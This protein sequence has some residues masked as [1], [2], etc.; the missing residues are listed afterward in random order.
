MYG[1]LMLLGIR[2]LPK[3]CSHFTDPLDLCLNLFSWYHDALLCQQSLSSHDCLHCSGELLPPAEAGAKLCSMT[4]ASL[5]WQHHMSRAQ[6][7]AACAL[8]LKEFQEQVL[9]GQLLYVLAIHGALQNM[10]SVKVGS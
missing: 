7:S 4:Q 2:A 5:A 6:L 3:H 8:V 9:C 1:I 10:H